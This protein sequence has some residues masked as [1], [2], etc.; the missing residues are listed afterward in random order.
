[1]SGISLGST[2]NLSK[3]KPPNQNYP[4]R[5]PTFLSISSNSIVLGPHG[6]GPIFIFILYSV[7]FLHLEELRV[8]VARSGELNHPVSVYTHPHANRVVLGVY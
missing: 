6:P 5:L 4:K 8:L 1:M 3:H 7:G 2:R